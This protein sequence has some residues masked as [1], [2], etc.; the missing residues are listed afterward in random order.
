MKRF[1]YCNRCGKSHRVGECPNKPAVK[2]P[3][4]KGYDSRWH[5]LRNAFLKLHPNC[6]CGREAVEVHHILPVRD[7]PELKYSWENLEALCKVCH[8]RIHSP[9]KKKRIS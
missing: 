9:R 7:Y 5:T 4:N 6:R 3:S 2:Q 1:V 8:A